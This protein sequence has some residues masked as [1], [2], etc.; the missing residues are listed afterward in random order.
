MSFNL[1]DAW[2][3][4]DGRIRDLL[5]KW[6]RQEGEGRLYARYLCFFA[7]VFEEVRKEVE[8]YIPQHGSENTAAAWRT[9]LAE[10]RSEHR[11]GLYARVANSDAVSSDAFGP[12][13]DVI[14]VPCN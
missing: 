2:P 3:A 10:K 14:V 9:H 1:G 8:Q 5:V 7:A 11:N 13:G 12:G 4:A 6:T